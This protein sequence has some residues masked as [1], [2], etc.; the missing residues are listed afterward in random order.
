MQSA[1]F[2]FCESACIADCFCFFI[3]KGKC[4]FEGEIKGRYVVSVFILLRYKGPMQSALIGCRV[5]LHRRLFLLPSYQSKTGLS[6]KDKR[7]IRCPRHTCSNIADKTGKGSTRFD[8][9][10]V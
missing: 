8:S 9:I 2:V 5:G 3:N 4:D 7:K 6:R 10:V 1:L